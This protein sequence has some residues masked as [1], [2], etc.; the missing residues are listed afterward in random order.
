M[1]GNTIIYVLLA[2]LILIIIFLLCR[3]LITWYWKLNEITSNQR[4]T[5]L[6]LQ[7]IY[8]Q[9][10]SPEDIATNAANKEFFKGKK[11]VLTGKFEGMTKQAILDRL[12]NLRAELQK[13]VDS[14]TDILIKGTDP[15]NL[16]ERYA[17]QYEVEQLTEAELY[18]ILG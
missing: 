10:K 17:I 18:K 1:T 13:E 2:L 8:D 6:L 14:K 16:K 15:E 5:N 11:V 9:I 3:E 4:K 7:N 12:S